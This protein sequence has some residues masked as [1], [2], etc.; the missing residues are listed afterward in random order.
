MSSSLVSG[1]HSLS[2]ALLGFFWQRRVRTLATVVNATRRSRSHLTVRMR[3]CF[4]CRTFHPMHMHWLKMFER[5][6]VSLSNHVTPG[7]S[8]FSAFLSCV[9]HSALGWTVWPSGRSDSKHRLGAQVLHQHQQRAHADQKKKPQTGESPPQ[10]IFGF[11]HARAIS[12]RHS[13]ASIVPTLLHQETGGGL[14][15]F[16]KVILQHQETGGGPRNCCECSRICV[17]EEERSIFERCANAVRQTK[18]P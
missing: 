14:R 7:C 5:F 16:W 3:T 15:Y 6:C 8:E 18:S 12:S 17:E 1:L 13:V 11:L 2:S 4:S 9:L 10:R